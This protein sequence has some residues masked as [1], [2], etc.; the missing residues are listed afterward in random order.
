[1]SAYKLV[2]FDWDGTLMDSVAH[3]VE[4]LQQAATTLE[5]PVPSIEAARNIIGLGL[6]EAIAILFPHAS[7][8]ARESIRQQYAHHFILGAPDKIQL[9]DGVMPLLTQLSEQGALSTLSHLGRLCRRCA[10]CFDRCR[11][12]SPIGR[13]FRAYRPLVYQEKSWG[14]LI[15]PH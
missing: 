12:L 3:I 7:S 5:Q 11:F 4:C 13:G 8:A 14:L 1:M 9:F 10:L 15:R 2:I 6:P